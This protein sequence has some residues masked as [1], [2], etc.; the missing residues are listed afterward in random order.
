[1]TYFSESWG[2]PLIP[3]KNLGLDFGDFRPRSEKSARDP[4][5]GPKS[6]SESE[7]LAGHSDWLASG[8]L[9]FW[10]PG[11]RRI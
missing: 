3:G 9:G 11:C 5:S 7:N 4:K 2:F 8:N 6:G 10:V 1:M